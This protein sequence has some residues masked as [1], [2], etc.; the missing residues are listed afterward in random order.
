MIV[1]EPQQKVTNVSHIHMLVAPW[2]MSQP[3]ISQLICHLSSYNPWCGQLYLPPPD[4]NLFSFLK[5]LI[6]QTCSFREENNNLFLKHQVTE[7]SLR[8]LETFQ[9]QG[10][11][12][13]RLSKFLN[14]EMSGVEMLD[15]SVFQFQRTNFS[16]LSSIIKPCPSHP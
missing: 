9:C 10:T 3:K 15:L 1:L 14:S 4:V 7:W 8:D 2:H 13:S 12:S 11:L 6:I 5:W 16:P